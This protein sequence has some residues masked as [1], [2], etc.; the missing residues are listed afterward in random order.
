VIVGKQHRVQ[1]GRRRRT[2]AT[3]VALAVVVVTLTGCGSSDCGDVYSRPIVAVDGV[4]SV[5]ADCSTQ[6]G[7]GWQRV[8][9]HLS[10]DDE[11]A[12]RETVG[13]VLEAVAADPD[14]EGLWALPRSYTRAD[15]SPLTDVFAGMTPA[16]EDWTG[17][18][19]TVRDLRSYLGIEP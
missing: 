3:A 1:G 13:R 17:N 9:V 6:F 11:P 10:A 12:A 19:S 15:G 14:V 4:E 16:G 2:A 5:E 8:D 7:G 18:L